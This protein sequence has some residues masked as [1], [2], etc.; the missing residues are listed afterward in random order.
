MKLPVPWTIHLAGHSISRTALQADIVVEG[1]PE[2]AC[3]KPSKLSPGGLLPQGKTCRL[4]ALVL[5][6]SRSP[7]IVPLVPAPGPVT[8]HLRTAKIFPGNT[9]T[10]VLILAFPV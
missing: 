3:S 1:S 2:P 7:G 5:S 9:K 10:E 4:T 6:G 8:R